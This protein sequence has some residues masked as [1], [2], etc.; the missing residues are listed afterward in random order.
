MKKK[1]CCQW[2][3][4]DCV[5]DLWKRVLFALL[6]NTRKQFNWIVKWMFK[7]FIS[8]YWF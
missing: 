7:Q 8:A 2:Y 6:K 1:N 4:W 5:M 3:F